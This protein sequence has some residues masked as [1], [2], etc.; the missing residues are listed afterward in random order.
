MTRDISKWSYWTGRPISTRFSKQLQTLESINPLQAKTK[1]GKD[2]IRQSRSL[3]MNTS[4]RLDPIPNMPVHE[5]TTQQQQ[6]ITSDPAQGSP[7]SQ[8]N[9]C[10]LI[11]DLTDSLYLSSWSFALVNEPV[12]TVFRPEKAEVYICFWNWTLENFILND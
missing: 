3:V 9:I 7:I 1:P 5:K 10:L 6:T 11:P 8:E 4:S 2:G 12:L